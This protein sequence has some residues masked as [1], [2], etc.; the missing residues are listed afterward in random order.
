MSP[1]QFPIENS[2]QVEA[3]P[4]WRFSLAE[5]LGFVSLVAFCLTVGR[6]NTGA[7]VALGIIV[8][9]ALF[10]ALRSARICKQRGISLDVRSHVANTCYSCYISLLAVAFYL[11]M[12][13]AAF[14]VCIVF[15]GLIGAEDPLLGVWMVAVLSVCLLPIPLKFLNLFKVRPKLRRELEW[16]HAS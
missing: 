5:L 10:H 9:P 11:E 8:L 2:H 3:A 14:C 12:I 7:G 15:L 16:R 1:S 13:F 4:L 6:W